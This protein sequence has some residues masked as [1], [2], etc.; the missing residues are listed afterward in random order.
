MIVALSV[1]GKD[2]DAAI[3]LAQWIT[4]LGGCKEFDALIVVD[5]QTPFD[6]AIELLECMRAAFRSATLQVT[7]K[8]VHGW[9]FGPNENWKTV[10]IACKERGRHWLF[11]EPDAIPLKSSWLQELDA[12]YRQCGKKYLGNIYDCS[13]PFLPSRVMSGVA[14]YGPDAIDDIAPLPNTPRAW[15]VDASERMV[16]QGAHTEKIKHLF[17]QIDFPPIFVQTKTSQSPPNAFTLDWLHPDCVLFH[18]DKTHSLLPLLARKLFPSEAREKI[19][20]CFPVYAG[21]IGLAITHAKWMQRMGRK[22]AHKAI[23]CHDPSCP[24]VLLNAFE[25]LLRVSFA[26]VESFVYSRPPIPTYPAAANFAFQSVALHMAKQKSPW[27]FFEADTVALKPDW[28]EQLQAEYDA[29]GRSWMGPHVQGMSHANGVMVYPADAAQRMPNAMSSGAHEAFDMRAA[30]DVMHD[31]HDCNHL[32][33][34]TWSILNGQWHPV[35]GG[36]VPANVTLDLAQKI[37]RS[38]CAIHRVKD[39]SL[40]N[41]L[42]T[43]AFKP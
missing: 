20:V 35:G 33:F 36:V 41:L 30:A 34:H 22:H 17:G 12:E 27:L 19:A 6:K 13:Q 32:L 31:C 9:P 16:S 29:C 25:Q 40:V 8:H 39:A 1:C 2:V 10:A 15:E 14:V 21:D 7:S 38:A 37:P 26:E 4:R 11:M 5:L 43:G 23:I 18:R 42:L 28:I 24:V 3:K